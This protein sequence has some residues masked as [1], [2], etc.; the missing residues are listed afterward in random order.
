MGNV[1]GWLKKFDTIFNRVI[2][3]FVIIVVIVVVTVDS[4]L[5]TR[6]SNNYNEKIE[7][8]KINQVGYLEIELD[9]VFQEANKII[10]EIAN[11]NNKDENVEKL[12]NKTLDNSYYNAF[13]ALDYF[14]LLANQNDNYVNGIEFYSLKNNLWLST[15]S[16][17]TYAN[18]DHEKVLEDTGI[19]KRKICY[20]G[21]IRWVS[22]RTVTRNNSEES[23]YSIA[24]GYPLY[25]DDPHKFKGYIVINFSK[26]FVDRILSDNLSDESDGVGIINFDSEIL[27]AEGNK[28]SLSEMI[29]NKDFITGIENNESEGYVHKTKDFILIGKRMNDEDW[30]VVN[31]VSK[32]AFYNETGRIVTQSI[33][34]SAIVI[35]FGLLFSYFFARNIYRP[36]FLIVNKLNPSAKLNKKAR[37]NEYYYIDRAIDELSKKAMTNEEMLSKNINSIKHDFVSQII[38]GGIKDSPEVAEKMELIGF[39]EDFTFNCLMLIGLHPKI[40]ETIEKTKLEI[41]YRDI[42]S[43][44][45]E[46]DSEE[47]LCI[48]INLLNSNICVFVSSKNPD[49]SHLEVIR[50]RLKDYLS[51]HYMLAPII[52]ESGIFEN[53][54]DA[55][56]KYREL[57]ELEKYVYFLPHTYF[58]DADEINLNGE[59]TDFAN[60]DF[61]GFTESLI[62]RNPEKTE[63]ILKRFVE[64]K[65]IFDYSVDVLHG[66]ILKYIFLY[67]FYLRDI[68]KEQNGADN[69]QIYKELAHLYD[70]EDFYYWFTALIKETFEILSSMENNPKKT[71]ITMVENVIMENLSEENLSLEYI[72]E[73]VYLSPKYISRIFKEETGSTVTQFTNECRLNKAAR[74]LLESNISLEELIKE[75][76]YSSTNYF[77]KKFK[78]KYSVTPT[79][80]RRNSVGQQ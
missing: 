35:L 23:V 77:I 8:L 7:S 40:K 74:M 21:D 9:R 78:E 28:E 56:E 5:I 76:G 52:I 51:I 50:K 22:T 1:F 70:V 44:F 24:A 62:A 30:A 17:I 79:Q 48:P 39:K 12:L 75:V 64:T 31:L 68:M 80:Y 69:M 37:E 45:Y 47:A 38:F 13:E 26:E 15:A 32:Q 34:I 3:S 18:S 60:S 63:E 42:I 71:V 2:F 41:I 58:L 33:L 20:D 4:F 14:N 36:F 29:R 53:I 46:Y 59:E 10:I 66:V 27:I 16:G 65:N 25:T 61:E 19:L 72:A 57:T 6:F 55:N 67:N 43:F 73:K 54:E 49:K 11:L